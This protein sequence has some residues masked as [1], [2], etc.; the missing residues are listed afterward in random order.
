MKF[1]PLIKVASLAVSALMLAS[2]GA[3]PS[4]PPATSTTAAPTPLVISQSTRKAE[5]VNA[6][7]S[8]LNDKPESTY[9]S[10]VI[11]D[12]QGRLVLVFFGSMSCPPIPSTALLE[13]SGKL[14]VRLQEQQTF[15]ACTADLGPVA[16]DAEL[17][18]KAVVK[19]AELFGEKG[20][21]AKVR[22]YNLKDPSAVVTPPTNPFTKSSK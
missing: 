6:L 13:E 2:C 12:E 7:L 17:P 19:S 11:T 4:T 15:K 20:Q 10:K 5:D 14:T 22:V 3:T 1:K 18:E 9:T 8:K 16:W 21:Q